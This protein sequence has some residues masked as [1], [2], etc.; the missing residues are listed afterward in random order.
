M[1]RY[2][3]RAPTIGEH[4]TMF[5]AVGWKPYNDVETERCLENSLYCIVAMEGEIIVGMGRLIG[6]R[7][8]FFYIQDLAVRPEYQGR[9]IGNILMTRI[10]DFVKN[11][12]VDEAFVG[13]FATDVAA[14][15]YAGFDILERPGALTGRFT[16]L[17][18]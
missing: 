9:G 6:D 10:M 3:D 14:D 16:I 1:L 7:G 11:E 18:K 13:L 5:E 17:R 4:A 12:I 2:E 15:F 8:K